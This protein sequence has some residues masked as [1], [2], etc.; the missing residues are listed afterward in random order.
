MQDPTLDPSLRSWVETANDPATDFPVQNLPLGMF[1]NS[2]DELKVGVAV[3]DRVVDLDMLVHSGALDAAAQEN[4]ELFH[5]VHHAVHHAAP[6]LL[7]ERPEAWGPTRRAVQQWL[8]EGAPGGQQSRRLREKACLAVSEVQLVE[9]CAFGGYTDFYASVHHATNV[10]SM[11]RPD[12]PLLPNYK[13]V[14][15]GYH[16]RAS[17]IVVSGTEIRRPKGQTGAPPEGKGQP[18]FGPCKRLD[19]E[20]ELGCVIGGGNVLGEPVGID[21]AHEL[22][23]GFVLVNDWSARDMQAWEY[24]PLGPFLAKNFATSVS[25]WI[26]TRQVLEPFRVAGPERGEGDPEPLPYLQARDRNW[27]LDVQLEVLL[28]SAKMRAAGQAPV[29]VSRGNLQRMF[30]TFPQMIAHHTSNGCNMTPGDLIASGTISGPEPESRGCMLELTWAGNGP[31]GKPLPRKPLTL[32]TGETRAFLEDG[33][34]VIM[35]GWCERSG[36]RRIG[37]GEC[38]GVIAPAR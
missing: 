38:R 26:V 1:I 16:G 5:T 28:S 2:E 21:R 29:R 24:Q 13:H 15:I 22:M 18:E 36:M 23:F 19:Y 7:M 4:E 12:N 8:L 11:F 27:G 14:P 10:G 17:S 6:Q 30:W 37:F 34:E 9:P 20:L 31:D 33:D 3:G 25:P 32:P 35:R